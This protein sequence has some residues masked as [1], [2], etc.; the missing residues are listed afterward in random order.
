MLLSLLINFTVTSFISFLLLVLFNLVLLPKVGKCKVWKEECW[1]VAFLFFSHPSVI[2]SQHHS[3]WLLCSQLIKSQCPG[4]PVCLLLELASVL[5]SLFPPPN[6]P[7]DSPSAPHLSLANLLRAILSSKH[8]LSEHQPSSLLLS[9]Q[10][11]V[12]LLS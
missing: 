4:L 3:P 11:S 2:L 8:I 10:F 9:L 12:Q 5:T 6:F 7:P 1:V